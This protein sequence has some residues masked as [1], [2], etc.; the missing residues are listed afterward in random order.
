ME[1]VLQLVELIL[2]VVLVGAFALAPGVAVWL[3]VAGVFVAVRR[4]RKANQGPVTLVDEK[5]LL[6]YQG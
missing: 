3:V 1:A 4:L 5:P 6:G 2:R